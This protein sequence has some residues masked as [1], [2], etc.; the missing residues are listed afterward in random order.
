MWEEADWAAENGDD[1]SGGR[2]VFL[3]VLGNGSP[4]SRAPRVVGMFFCAES[5]SELGFS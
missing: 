4:A 3:F 5:E 1:F 2:A